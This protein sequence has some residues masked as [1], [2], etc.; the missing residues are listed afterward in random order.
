MTTWKPPPALGETIQLHICHHAEEDNASAR[1][2]KPDSLSRKETRYCDGHH[3]QHGKRTFDS[4]RSRNQDGFQEEIDT[5][6]TP[7]KNHQ[8]VWGGEIRKQESR[9][10][11]DGIGDDDEGVIR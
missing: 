5:D 3:V 4:S 10:N 6:L 2:E 7:E 1:R 9:R 8:R 11:G